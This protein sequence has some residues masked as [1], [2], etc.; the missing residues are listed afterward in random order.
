MPLTG[1]VL[2]LV[3]YENGAILQGLNQKGKRLRQFFALFFSAKALT[4]RLRFTSVDG[5]HLSGWR[6]L[7]DDANVLHIDEA[8]P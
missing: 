7:F 8:R 2:D 1:K 5:V 3:G 4:E 6:V